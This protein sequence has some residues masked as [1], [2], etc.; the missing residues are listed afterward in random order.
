L[1][2]HAEILRGVH[3]S[4]DAEAI[5]VLRSSPKWE[6]PA[7]KEGVPV[8]VSYVVPLNFELRGNEKNNTTNEKVSNEQ[9][10][11]DEVVVVGYGKLPD[12]NV[13]ITNIPENVLYIVDG[14][15][16]DSV[17]DIAPEDIASIEVLKDAAAIEKYGEKAQNGV[18][19]IERK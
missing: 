9:K 17:A 8:K 7:T 13:K 5:R 2:T 10:V 15:E 6:K 19:I 14:Q 12:E 18:I 1:V 3:P 4:I 11:L 16:V